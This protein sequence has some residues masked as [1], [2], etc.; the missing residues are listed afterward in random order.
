MILE[1]IAKFVVIGVVIT[2][3]L[4]YSKKKSNKNVEIDQSGFFIL[5]I[6]KL[7]KIIGSIST[8][9]AVVLSIV[10]IYLNSR[11]GY[12]VLLTMSFLLGWLGIFI[13]M[14][15]YNHK[16]EF[17]DV[18]MRVINI[19][20]RTKTMSWNDVKEIKFEPLKGYIY[21]YSEKEKLKI[22]Q[23][24]VGLIEFV[25]IMEKN[26]NYTAKELKLPLHRK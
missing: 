12:I 25:K 17:N 13:L 4:K 20:G 7:Y 3:F 6:N 5:K 21:L 18:N 15:Y 1:D 11:Q 9:F 2:M 22:H 10:S 14:F 24:L 8:G 23:H 16:F 26:T 19:Y